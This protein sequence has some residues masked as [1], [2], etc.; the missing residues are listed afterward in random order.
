L[1]ASAALV[2]WLAPGV[3]PPVF[4]SLAVSIA[5]G[6]SGFAI[7]MWAWRQFQ[8]HSVAVCP[9]EATSF[10]ITDGIYRF[11][12]NPMYLGIVLM[13]CGLAVLLGSLPFYIVTLVYFLVIDRV[14]CP[15]EER[16][17]SATF[18]TGYERYRSRVRRWL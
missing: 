4:S 13:L 15:F 5:L 16:K 12:R 8:V 9:T 11:T 2:H 10:L 18:G 17:L 6:V 14:F 7:M 3:S 1:V